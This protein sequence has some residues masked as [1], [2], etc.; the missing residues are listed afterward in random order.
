MATATSPDA[1][2]KFIDC[3][4]FPSETNCTLRISGKEEEVLPVAARHAA[5]VHGHED[6]P[7]LR[8]QLRQMLKDE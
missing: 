4:E 3:S 7:E 1:G 2:R 6:T 5:D 8:E